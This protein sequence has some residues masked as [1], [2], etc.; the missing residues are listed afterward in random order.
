[1]SS[2]FLKRG[3]FMTE[4][5]GRKIKKAMQEADLTQAELAKKIGIKKQQQKRKV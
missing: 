3:V 2:L 5:I 1:M 4:N